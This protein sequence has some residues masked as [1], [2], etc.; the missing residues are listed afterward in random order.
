MNTEEEVLAILTRTGAF[1][2]Q[3]HF[4]GTSGRHLD[5][6]VNKDALFT[7][8]QEA[9][10][11]GELFAQMNKEGAIDV[12]AAPATGGIVLSQ[13]TA[14]HLSRISGNEVLSVY[15]EKTPE[16][17]QIFKRGYDQIVKGKRVLIL[18][19]VTTTGGSVKKV[20][21]SV[22]GA[23]GTVVRVCVMV[24]RDVV[25]VTSEAIGAPFA[26]LCTISANSYEA[27]QCPLCAQGVTVDTRVGHGSAFLKQH[28]A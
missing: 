18:E 14:Y 24:N 11:I 25:Q 19:D 13:W 22:I 26:S 3:G 5:A 17:G 23:G 8:T 12:V 4:V 7:H 20:M 10:R 2:P 1:L 15:T 16:N 6:Y 28:A 27:S 9:C 21:E